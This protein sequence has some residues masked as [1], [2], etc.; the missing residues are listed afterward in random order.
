MIVNRI[1]LIVR[2]MKT[3]AE[4]KSKGWKLK[5]E[6]CCVDF[7]KELKQEFLSDDCT[8]TTKG[9]KETGRKVLGGLPE[10]G[11]QIRR[12]CGRMKKFRSMLR[13]KG[14]LLI[15]GTLREQKT[16]VQR[17]NMTA[18]MTGQRRAW[19]GKEMEMGRMCIRLR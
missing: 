13:G 12:L 4:Q 17:E 5:K 18:C 7:W 16:K 1:N 2:K 15:G 10:C 9:I 3:R 19:Q 11:K 6:E 14:K 8:A